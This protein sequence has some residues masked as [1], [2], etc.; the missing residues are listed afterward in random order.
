MILRY[1]LAA[2]IS[3]GALVVE[4]CSGL[5]WG[6]YIMDAIARRVYAI[7]IDP[8]AIVAAASLWQTRNTTHIQASVLDMPLASGSVDVALA[9]ESIEHF[10]IG[11]IHRYLDELERV[12]CPGGQL[13]GSTAFP[14]SRQAADRLRAKNHSH[15]HICTRCELASLLSDR[16]HQ[17]RLYRG[18]YFW[19]RK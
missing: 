9:M 10:S 19:A 5:G 13:V 18:R 11:D 7:E 17:Y 4:T 16:F 6:A 1:A 15:L 14:E 8:A 2:D 3:R 12:L